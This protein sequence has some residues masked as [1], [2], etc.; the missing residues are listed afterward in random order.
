VNHTN[1]NVKT[2]FKENLFYLS[3]CRPLSKQPGRH[4]PWHN[5]FFKL[6]LIM[7]QKAST[8]WLPRYDT[9]YPFLFRIAEQSMQPRCE[10]LVGRSVQGQLKKMTLNGAFLLHVVSMI[11]IGMFDLLGF[12]FI[13]S[14]L[15][16]HFSFAIG[17]L[18]SS[19]WSKRPLCPAIACVKAPE[20]FTAS[21][22]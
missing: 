16:A 21:L 20:G 22:E 3:M 17:P 10:V 7:D 15:L 4:L 1:D 18:M 8:V 9:R 5:L 14:F 12:R 2:V 19:Y 6:L 13:V 11:M